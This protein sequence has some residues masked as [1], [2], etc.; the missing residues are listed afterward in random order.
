MLIAWLVS[1]FTARHWYETKQI[2]VA[3]WVLPWQISRKISWLLWAKIWISGEMCAKQNKA[4]LEASCRIAFCITL[5]KKSHTT[6]EE[7]IKPVSLKRLLWYW[8]R[9]KPNKLKEILLSNDTVKKRHFVASG[10]RGKVQ[11]TIFLAIG[12]VHWYFILCLIAGLRLLHLWK[13][14]KSTNIYFRNHF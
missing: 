4:V 6:G 5:A 8:R 1:K 10:G 9:K 3:F 12:W 11:P 7:L 2:E 13:Q 14:C